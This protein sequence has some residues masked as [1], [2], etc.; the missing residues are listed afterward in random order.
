MCQRS[1]KSYK[2]TI[3]IFGI[4]NCSDSFLSILSK[5]T[6]T[7]LS[8]I[9]T[10]HLSPYM[11]LSLSYFKKMRDFLFNPPSQTQDVFRRDCF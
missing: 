5:T 10:I 1:L 9:I 4:F 7:P 6:R 8:L 11:K 3:F 2:K